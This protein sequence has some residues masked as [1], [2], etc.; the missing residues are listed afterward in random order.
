MTI[1]MT[2]SQENFNHVLHIHSYSDLVWRILIRTILLYIVNLSH[3]GFVIS[4]INIFFFLKKPVVGQWD[5]SKFH[6]PSKLIVWRQQF[7]KNQSFGHFGP[8]ILG[9][10]F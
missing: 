4:L 7:M 10:V 8:N 9:H 5:L 3:K 2:I 1:M 6:F